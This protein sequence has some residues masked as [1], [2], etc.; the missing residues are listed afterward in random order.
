[1]TRKRRYGGSDELAR[2]RDVLAHALV[3]GDALAASTAYA[4]DAKL[5]APATGL[6]EGRGEIEAFWRAGIEAGVADLE[7]EP[8]V[9][10]HGDAIAYEIGDYSLRVGNGDETIVD[11]GTYALVH[12][13][14]QDGRWLRTL[15][16]LNPVAM[17]ASCT[18]KPKLEGGSYASPDPS[19]PP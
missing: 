8:K 16:L 13:R 19:L 18:S 3:A 12:Q 17:S 4:E 9:V 6:V 2:A 7:L 10:E 1:M 11:L 14:Q 15:E 5:L